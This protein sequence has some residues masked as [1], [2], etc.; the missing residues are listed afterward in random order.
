MQPSAWVDSLRRI[1]EDSFNIDWS[2]EVEEVNLLLQTTDTFNTSLPG[3][4]PIWFQGD[5]EAI[6]PGNWT[7]VI[8]LNHQRCDEVAPPPGEY[9]DW[10]RG[11]LRTSPNTHFFTPLVKVA[12]TALAH[13]FPDQGIWEY[14]ATRMIFIEL[15]PFAS[16]DFSLDAKAVV[17][18]RKT[19]AMKTA[20]TFREILLHAACPALV[21]VNGIRAV[22]SFTDDYESQLEAWVQ[23]A[24]ASPD[25]HEKKLR[26][27]QGVLSSDIRIPVVG[28]PFLRTPKS[29]N[30]H[31][32]I[33]HLVM[34]IA[35]FIRERPP[36][37]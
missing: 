2:K 33:D 16:T 18:L 17:T 9:W 28:F 14:A 3:L 22:E 1:H 15:C 29:H 10:C 8:S 35:N 31:A 6:T 36:E 12:S 25:H 30:S 20:A 37:K 5:V 23:V 32:E 26:H 11:H 19:I 27:W 7:L 34:R 24:Y 21:L 4:P 13:E